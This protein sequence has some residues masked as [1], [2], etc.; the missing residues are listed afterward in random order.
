MSFGSN[1]FGNAA[2]VTLLVATAAQPVSADRGPLPWDCVANGTCCFV[3]KPT[4]VPFRPPVID[5]SFDR[6]DVGAG[7]LERSQVR[8]V[9]RRQSAPLEVCFERASG[10][11]DVVIVIGPSG[12]AQATDAT[13]KDP[14]IASC[15][16]K[17]LARVSFPV[18]EDNEVTQVAVTITG[19]RR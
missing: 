4:A 15:V 16:T 5:V 6:V 8:R 13:S 12:G 7:G 10:S 17:A 1:L 11:V 3:Q 2:A 9:L 19:V 18:A 14:R